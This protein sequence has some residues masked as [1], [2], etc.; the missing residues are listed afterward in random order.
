MTR[1]FAQHFPPWSLI[2]WLNTMSRIDVLQDDRGLATCVAAAQIKPEWIEAYKTTH[3]VATL[4]DFVYLVTASDWE[5]SLK[6]L[7]EGVPALKGNRIAMARFKSAYECGTVALKQAAQPAAKSEDP[8]ELLP[9]GTMQQL[10]RDWTKRYSLHFEPWFEPS[11]QLRSRVYREWRKQSMTVIDA[12][13][14]RSMMHIT[15][16]KSKE[17]VDLPGGIQL[18]FDREY[19]AN[20]RSVADYYAALGILAHCWAWSGNYFVQYNSENILMCDLSSA[21]SYADRAFRDCME[22]GHGSLNWLERNDTLTRGRMAMYVRRGWPASVSLIEALRECHLEWRS[23]AVLP[24]P[25][26]PEP[27]PKSSRAEPPPEP[28]GGPPTKRATPLKSDAHKTVSMIKGGSKL[29]KPYKDG[30]GC[31]DPSCTSLHQC[32]VKL[33]SGAPCLSKKHTRLEHE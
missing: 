22:Y 1:D 6:E 32:D 9:E 20:F 30:R 2:V 28:V 21:L 33:P 17:Q 16:P 14:I 5:A 25:S 29:C 4:D 31:R 26:S 15:T 8:D 18:Q 3:A 24:Q 10:N 12:K 19:S 11:E 13:K 7:V 23:P 27:K